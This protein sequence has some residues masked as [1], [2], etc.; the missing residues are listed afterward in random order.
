MKPHIHRGVAE[1]TAHR[2]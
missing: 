1:A 2:I